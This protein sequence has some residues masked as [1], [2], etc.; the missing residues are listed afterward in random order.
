MVQSALS[1]EEEEEAEE[2]EDMAAPMALR[3]QLCSSAR[4]FSGMS[5]LVQYLHFLFCAL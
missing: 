1:K 3:R 2:E 5:H 4:I